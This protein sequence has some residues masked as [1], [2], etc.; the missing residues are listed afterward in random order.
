MRIKAAEIGHLEVLKRIRNNAST[1]IDWIDDD[2]CASAAKGGHLEVLKWA[3]NNGCNW[4]EWTCIFVI[5]N[6]HFEVLGN[7]PKRTD[8][9]GIIMSVGWPKI[10]VIGKYGNG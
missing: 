3:R 5:T 8:V 9:I 4:D 7:G 6:G 1:T 10:P 2:I